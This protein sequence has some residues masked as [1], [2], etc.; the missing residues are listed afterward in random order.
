VVDRLD[1][2]KYVEE[3]FEGVPEDERHQI[4]AGNAIELYGL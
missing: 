3:A 4:M 1:S 2:W